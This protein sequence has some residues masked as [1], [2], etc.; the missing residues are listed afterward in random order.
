M[1]DTTK[2]WNFPKLFKLFNIFLYI[3]RG[4]VQKVGWVLHISQAN[5]NLHV[6][7]NISGKNLENLIIFSIEKMH[8]FAFFLSFLLKIGISHFC[9]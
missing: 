5:F 1:N 2:L 6:I 8:K 7:K 9:E 4:I 3:Y